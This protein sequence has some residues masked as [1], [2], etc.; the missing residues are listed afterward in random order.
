[1]AI[2]IEGIQ[3]AQKAMLQA[4]AAAK[5]DNGPKAAVQAGTIAAHRYATSITH[6]DTGALR[7]SH[8]IRLRRTEGQVYINPGARR[9]DGAR[10]AEYGPY[11]H[12]RGGSHAFYKRTA[13][14]GSKQIGDA[15]FDA[16]RRYLP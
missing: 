5:P 15:A 8:F 9:S 6:V 11:E 10:P 3:E 12:A 2:K 1:M 13:E 4:A 7:A 16:F 14:H